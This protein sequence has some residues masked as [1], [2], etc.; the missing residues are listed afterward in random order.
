MIDL[1]VERIDPLPERARSGEIP[2]GASICGRVGNVSRGSRKQ[3]EYRLSNWAEI[4]TLGQIRNN[5]AWEWRACRETKS[6]G[7]SS[8]IDQLPCEG[9]KVAAARRRR[10]HGRAECVWNA[11]P[12]PEVVPEEE[13]T[14]LDDR[15]AD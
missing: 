11:V 8:G 13:G 6:V 10:W 2:L 9:G 3:V 5:V 4:R 12:L 15:A 14:I 7:I 1:Y